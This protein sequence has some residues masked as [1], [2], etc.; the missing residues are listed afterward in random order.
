MNL[1]C[2][3]PSLRFGYNPV[4]EQRL[5]P[6][7]EALTALATQLSPKLEQAST[8]PQPLQTMHANNVAFLQKQGLSTNALKVVNAFVVATAPAMAKAGFTDYWS[9]AS[10][11][12]KLMV[13]GLNRYETTVTE[14]ELL[15]AALVGWLHDG[16]KTNDFAANQFAG[17]MVAHPV[18][19]QAYAYNVLQTAPVAGA[20]AT[21]LNHDT[22]AIE[23][24]KN[25]VVACLG[26][27]DDSAFVLNAGLKPVLAEEALQNLAQQRFKALTLPPKQANTPE[28]PEASLAQLQKKQVPTGFGELTVPVSFLLQATNPNNKVA[29]ALA[30]ADQLSLSPAKIIAS[31]LSRKETPA[32]AMAGVIQS[33]EENANHLPYA[34]KAA[35]LPMLLENLLLL[36]KASR[37]A[38]STSVGLTENMGAKLALT[39][40]NPLGMQQAVKQLREELT[41][42]TF[43]GEYG[44][45][46]LPEALASRLQQHLA[47]GYTKQFESKPVFLG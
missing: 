5:R 32:L 30:Y 2:L 36:K 16:L 19:A 20:L 31:E 41:N 11:V 14:S 46:K 15:E 37:Q 42:P 21:F 17:N 9:H 23:A 24:F 34:Y 4:S 44:N 27:N 3:T 40:G 6:S 1:F 38:L 10:Q 26:A 47:Q 12:M 35:G 7:S 22:P 45:A 25:N 8:S 18:L 28:V 39:T 43:W 33:L 13:K 29:T